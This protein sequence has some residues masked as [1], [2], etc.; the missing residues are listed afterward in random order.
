VNGDGWLPMRLRLAWDEP[1][2]VGSLDEYVAV[3]GRAMHDAAPGELLEIDL[4]GQQRE[5]EWYCLRIEP[6]TC[7]SCDVRIAYASV[8]RDSG[9]HHVIVWPSHDDPNLYS[10]IDQFEGK[11]AI[12]TFEHEFGTPVSYYS[13]VPS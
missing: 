6:W 1:I 7:P 11:A 2:R 13:L 9:Q 12:V 5:D 10:M 3:F 4:G 8:P